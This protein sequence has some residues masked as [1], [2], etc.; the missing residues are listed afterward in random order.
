MIHSSSTGTKS[1]LP[2]L[3]KLKTQAE[4]VNGSI[5]GTG[6]VSVMDGELVVWRQNP[7]DRSELVIVNRKE[8]MLEGN[9][10]RGVTMVVYPPEDRIENKLTLL[11]ESVGACSV[12][13]NRLLD[14]VVLEEEVV[15]EEVKKHSPQPVEKNSEWFSRELEKFYQHHDVHDYN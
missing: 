10:V 5:V 9:E 6:I 15:E 4:S 11:Q 13:L 7:D 1:T 8:L 12:K 14:E 3:D 2:D